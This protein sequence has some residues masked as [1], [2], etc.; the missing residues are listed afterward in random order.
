MALLTQATQREKLKHLLIAFTA[1]NLCF[2]RRWY[3]LERLEGYG[4]DYY[5]TALIKNRKSAALH[6]KMGIAE[7]L[8]Q[9]WPEAKKDFDSAIK[10]DNSYADAYNNLGVIFYLSRKYSKAVDRYEHAIKLR[11]ASASYYS[12]MGA[13]YFSKKDF[14]RSLVAYGKALELDPDVFERSSHGGVAAQMA[15]PEDRARYDFEVAKLYA[16]MGV[17]DRS[18]QYLRRAM[19]EGYKNIDSV[20]KDVEFA[21][22]RKDPRFTELMV[23]R[24]PAIPE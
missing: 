9:H 2:I 13:A 14:Q 1:G 5:R 16:K 12:N 8:L 10:Y 15:K 7:L 21:G 6:N 20:Y 22:L 4:L 18:L 17:S 23:A 24:P 19:E 3:D 11:P